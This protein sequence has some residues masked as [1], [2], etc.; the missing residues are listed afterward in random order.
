[1]PA[2]QLLFND[3]ARAKILTGVQTLARAVAV[4]LGPKGRNVIIEKPYGPPTVTKDGVSVAKEVEL[5]DKYENL[6]AQLVREVAMKT[7]D[8]A[9]DG[10]TTATVLAE[11]IY[12][13]GIKAVNGGASP[14][15][16]K[17]G[18]D[19][20]VEATVAYL[21]K[22]SK[23]VENTEEIRQVATVSANWDEMIGHLIADAME[24]VGKDGTITVEEAKSIETTLD[25]VEGMQLDRGYVS[26]HFATNAETAQC[27]LDDALVLIYE[28]KITNI[29]QILPALQL[30]NGR[31]LLIIAEDIDPET[32]NTLIMNKSRGKLNIAVIK[33]PSFGKL[34]SDILADVAVMTGGLVFDDVINK[35]ESVTEKTLG[36]AVRILVEEDGTT[37]VK[38]SGDKAKVEARCAHIRSLVKGSESDFERAHFVSR[39]AKLSGGI[40][41]ISVG[42]PT[43]AEMREK[44]DRVE[45][46]LH[47]TR[48]AVAEGIVAGGGIALIRASN[49]AFCLN[50]T[51]DE[52]IGRTIVMLAIEA[53][54]RQL[55]RNAGVDEQIIV[56]DVTLASQDMGYNVATGQIEDLLKAG[57]VDPTKVTRNALQNAASIAG[58]LLTTECM[59]IIAP[60]NAPTEENP[61]RES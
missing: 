28:R 6:G 11:A 43:E 26:T 29:S 21:A 33:S 48:A 55:C 47:A 22:I 9:G 7:S 37:I 20:T 32:L 15:H 54:L 16:I 19:K 60:T 30:S 41:V 49:A 52:D 1:M 4:T 36:S 61:F 3:A 18:I 34:R 27:V 31:S 2:K 53:P 50:L 24:R 35:I 39:L 38:G 12:R 10:T 23:P 57:V 5:A 25:V 42:A 14:V 44:K 58:L 45:D 40:A 13:E 51:P 59:I 17:R 46:A 8:A 56:R